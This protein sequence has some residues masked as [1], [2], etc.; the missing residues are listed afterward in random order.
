M[1]VMAHDGSS[2]PSQAWIA[3]RTFASSSSML[4]PW[5]TQP[6]NAGTSAEPAF[7]RL[8]N[9]HFNLQGPNGTVAQPRWRVAQLL[10]SFDGMRR[11]LPVS[12]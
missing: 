9:D 10:I 12:P 6:G 11:K 7:F 3:S 1:G 2:V 8:V 4:S 5:L